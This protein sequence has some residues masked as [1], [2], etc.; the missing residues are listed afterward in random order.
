MGTER[1]LSAHDGGDQEEAVST[2]TFGTFETEWPE[3]SK[4]L[5]STLARRRI[6]DSLR[7]DIIQE[8]GL[9]L[10]RNWHTL[11]PERSPWPF[12]LTIAINLIRDQIR[13]Q[14]RA[15][16]RP[17]P[18]ERLVED[19]IERAALARIELKRVQRA[20]DQLTDLQRQTLLAEIG[21]QR[22]EESSST[23]TKMV[24]MRARRRL[25]TILEHASGF[26]TVT[27]LG[28]RRL[29][30]RLHLLPSR[31][32]LGEGFQAM[33]SAGVCF[34]CAVGIVG[35]MVTA[36]PVGRG[37]GIALPEGF[38]M[39]DLSTASE[40]ISMKLAAAPSGT[41]IT[42]GPSEAAAAQPAS[43]ANKPGGA[44]GHSVGVGEDGFEVGETD[45]EVGTDGARI[46]QELKGRIQGHEVRGRF[47][48]GLQSPSS[49]RERFPCVDFTPPQAEAEVEV[50]GQT[51]SVKPGSQKAAKK[52]H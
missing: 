33:T 38:G 1:R 23:A 5:K 9:R 25:R 13:A 51:Y 8:T 45:H 42:R 47:A 6:P 40:P 7:E 2:T 43:H 32:G 27:G 39:F 31:T 17:L 15:E 50:D 49:C 18:A 46:S 21:Y 26:A 24:R 28:A 10:F 4:R 14:A 3:I 48:T 12:A 36:G 16:Q 30:R 41:S 29:M 52:R 35:G 22:P 20:L 37:V 19:D 44:G 11:D 34:L